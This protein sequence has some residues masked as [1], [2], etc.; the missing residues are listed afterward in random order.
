[1]KEKKM[2]YALVYDHEL[3]LIFAGM[4]DEKL[5][6]DK[7]ELLLYLK[8]ELPWGQSLADIS[9]ISIVSTPIETIFIRGIQELL[10]DPRIKGE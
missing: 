7:V 1:M 5:L 9:K 4:I 8:E 6:K 3:T 10:D 2:K